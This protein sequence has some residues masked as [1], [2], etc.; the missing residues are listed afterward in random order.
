MQQCWKGYAEA[1]DKGGH[2]HG[3]KFGYIKHESNFRK[4]RVRFHTV[5]QPEPDQELLVKP[6]H[7]YHCEKAVTTKRGDVSNM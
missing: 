5:K 2:W 3:W 4:M 6:L 1:A 7:F